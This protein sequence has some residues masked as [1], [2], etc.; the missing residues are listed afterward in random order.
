MAVIALACTSQINS[1]LPF[2]FP[3]AAS[4]RTRRTI[5]EIRF[6]AQG[7]NPSLSIQLFR[8]DQRANVPQLF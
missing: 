8:Q 7:T 5:F 6:P 2:P 4:R 3:V 1:H